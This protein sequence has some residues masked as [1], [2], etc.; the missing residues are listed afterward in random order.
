MFILFLFLNLLLILYVE[1]GEKKIL[2][3]HLFCLIALEAKFNIEESYM[4]QFFIWF[5]AREK[6]KLWSV[7]IYSLPIIT[8][9]IT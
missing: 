1:P 3:G 9:I 4:P 8:L 7:I 2:N 6:N 5:S